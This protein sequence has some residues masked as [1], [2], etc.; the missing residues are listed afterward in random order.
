MLVLGPVG[1][2]RSAWILDTWRAHD[3]ARCPRSAEVGAAHVQLEGAPMSRDDVLAMVR[4]ERVVGIVRR[5]RAKDAYDDARALLGAGL[6]I[7][8][9]SLTTPRAVDVI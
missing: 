4:R 1:S 2:R 7:V 6:G 5:A 9:V 3:T 8:E